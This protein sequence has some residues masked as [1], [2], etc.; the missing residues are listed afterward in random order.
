M[1]KSDKKLVPAIVILSLCLPL[2]FELQ[3]S[4]YRPIKRFDIRPAVCVIEEDADCHSRF[5]FSWD[6]AYATRVCLKPNQHK[7]F[8]VCDDNPSVEIELV[9]DISDNSYYD[10][11]PQNN[12]QLRVSR[13]IEVQRLNQ[14]VRILNRRIW[15][16]F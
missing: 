8:L 14:D 7:E 1:M 16:V 5:I 9:I 6:L 4:E 11:I 10:L 12:A 15:S 3:A 2:L 13:M